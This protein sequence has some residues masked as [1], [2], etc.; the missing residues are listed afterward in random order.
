MKQ[1]LHRNNTH[2]HVPGAGGAL[3]GG[4]GCR[5]SGSGC[6]CA[7]SS[8]GALGGGG[9]RGGDSGRG[10]ELSSFLDCSIPS[11]TEGKLKQNVIM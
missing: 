10:W 4:G 9:E 11:I 5:T 3:S 8:A 7:L 1:I 6:D 2:I